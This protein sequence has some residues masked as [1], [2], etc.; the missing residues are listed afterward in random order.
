MCLRNEICYPPIQFSAYELYVHW[1]KRLIVFYRLCHFQC[2]SAMIV[3]SSISRW[4][5]IKYDHIWTIKQFLGISRFL[6]KSVIARKETNLHGFLCKQL[7]PKPYKTVYI[8]YIIRSCIRRHSVVSCIDEIMT[9][10]FRVCLYEPRN[11]DRINTEIL[12]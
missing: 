7:L 6:S 5:Y 11:S 12:Q 8:Q 1:K 2:S 9:V 4:S 3:I 10:L